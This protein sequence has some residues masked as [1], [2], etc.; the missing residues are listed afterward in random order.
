MR[1]NPQPNSL[2]VATLFFLLAALLVA[3]MVLG[4]PAPS[5]AAGWLAARGYTRTV[6][7]ERF[8]A[9]RHRYLLRG[10]W[11]PS[12]PCAAGSCADRLDQ[13]GKLVYGGLTGERC[14]GAAI[15]GARQGG[16]LECILEGMG[17]PAGYRSTPE[18]EADVN[19]VE[20][21]NGS[22]ACDA[23]ALMFGCDLP[24]PEPPA[25]PTPAPTAT[26]TPVPQPT[27]TPTPQP[28]PPPCAHLSAP[29]PGCGLID[30]LA[31]K[32]LGLLT[33]GAKRK[34]AAVEC[35]GWLD[36]ARDVLSTG[37]VEVCVN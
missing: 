14:S 25:T 22:N 3:A 33:F 23:L 32:A 21:G 2:L 1:R 10:T 24:A 18:D 15:V 34:A 16:R 28:T 35:K 27:A 30:T 12:I 29:P 6:W 31:S 19:Y 37:R 5:S 7:V 20:V 26:P 4:Q 36:E 11:H 13:T 8:D 9:A 17:L